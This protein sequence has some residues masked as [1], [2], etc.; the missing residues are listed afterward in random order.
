MRS[1]LTHPV[2]FDGRNMYDASR[3]SNEGFTYIGIGVQAEASEG[4][5]NA[6]IDIERLM[7]ITAD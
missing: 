2:V 3:V 6:E 4:Q 5:T 7:T 1:E